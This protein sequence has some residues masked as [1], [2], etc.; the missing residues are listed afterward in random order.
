[1]SQQNLWNL[2][3]L[4]LVLFELRGTTLTFNNC[5]RIRWPNY[6]ARPSGLLMVGLLGRKQWSMMWRGFGYALMTTE[7]RDLEGDNL[8]YNVHQD[9]IAKISWNIKLPNRVD[10]PML[11]PHFTGTEHHLN[12][13][14][15]LRDLQS[16]TGWGNFRTDP[17]V[18][19]FPGV[20]SV[21]Q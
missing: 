2:A 10:L 14:G 7:W 15:N 3:A 4:R 9:S 17:T 8:H 21:P 5:R 18:K 16:L 13:S 6:L 1:M 11:I 20:Q 19:L 12:I